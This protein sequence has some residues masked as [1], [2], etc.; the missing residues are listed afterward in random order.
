[1]LGG[2][3]LDALLQPHQL[4]ALVHHVDEQVGGQA[5]GAVGHPLDHIGVHQRGDAHGAAL[6]VDLGV[7]VHHLKLADHVAELPQLPV[8]Q[9]LGAVPVQHGDLV[10]G[11]LRHIAGEVPGLKGQQ[12]RVGPRPED[13]AAGDGPHQGRDQ[14]GQ[15]QEEGDGALLFQKG[16]VFLRPLGLEPGGQQGAAAVHRAQHQGKDI[17]I[18]RFQ[19]DRRQLRVE[20]DQGHR[21]SDAQ[22]DEHPGEGGAD[23]PAGFLLPGRSV[24]LGGCA[25]VE[26][27]PV[28]AAGVCTGKSHGVVSFSDFRVGRPSHGPAPDRRGGQI[29]ASLPHFSRC[30]KGEGGLSPSKGLSHGKTEEILTKNS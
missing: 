10:V 23:G 5:F 17:E 2:G 14:Q 6:V 20:I 25:A 11:D 27:L 26:A 16:E 28:E 19:V 18:G 12:L 13:H 15:G 9:P 4:H 22:V 7:V 1:M 30:G 8:P 21:Q 24:S 29:T 3:V